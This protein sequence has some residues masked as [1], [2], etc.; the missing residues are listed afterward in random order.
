MRK[1]LLADN[2][3]LKSRK[4]ISFYLASFAKEISYTFE[5][6]DSQF[7]NFIRAFLTVSTIFLSIC[8]LL[9]LIS[10]KIAEKLVGLEFF[11]T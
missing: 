1:E 10:N 2:D 7:F 11:K 8:V 6:E 4:H 9:K 5:L 3:C